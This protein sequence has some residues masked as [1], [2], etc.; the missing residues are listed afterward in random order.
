MTYP[1]GSAAAD[2]AFERDRDRAADAHF[3]PPLP[4]CPWCGVENDHDE[5]YCEECCQ[6]M[7]GEDFYQCPYCGDIKTGDDAREGASC[8]K[9]NHVELVTLTKE[10]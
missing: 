3:A 8:C 10:Q 9:E 1:I 5:E 7:D 6:P 4:V 2:A